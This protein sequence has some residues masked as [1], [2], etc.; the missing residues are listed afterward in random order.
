MSDFDGQIT[1]N[2]AGALIPEEVSQEIIQAVPAA[3]TV[4]TLGRRLPNMARAQYRLP[5]F[6]ALVQAYFVSGD[7]GLKKV[8]KAAWKNVYVYAE[9]IAAIIPIPEAVLDDTS[10]DIWGETKPKLVEAFGAL[11]DAAVLLGT[12]KPA[13][14]PNGLLAGAAA[15]GQ[16]VAEGTGADLYDDIMAEGGVLSKV[17]EDDFVITGHVGAARMK[18]KLRGL[19]SAV[20]GLPLFTRSMQ[21]GNRYELDGEPIYFPRNGSMDPA[22]ALL[23]AGDWKQLVYSI[24]QDMTYK[25][26][27]E[28]VIQDD[29]G[30]IVYNLAQQDMVALRAVMRVGWALPNPINRM[31][32]VDATRY[33]FA[34]LAP[35]AGS[36][37]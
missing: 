7:T 1:R 23:F 10:Y 34:V 11:F 33:P 6:N 26:L 28:A 12:N 30:S 32:T 25:I 3:S 31:A 36:G 17:E 22:Q 16:V 18:A 5:V 8:T 21:E 29:E 24:R 14:W 35:A 15:A 2:D 9:E 19:R 20:E 37:S 13:N 27:T 4:M